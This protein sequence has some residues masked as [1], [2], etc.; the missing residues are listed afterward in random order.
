MSEQLSGSL[1]PTG[2]ITTDEVKPQ[3]PALAPKY[4]DEG[5]AKLVTGDMARAMA[6]QQ[7]K[8]W[9]LHWNESDVLYQSPRG[10]TNFD[11]SVVS[12]ANVSRFDVAKHVNSLAPMIESGLFYETPPFVIRPRPGQKQNT[13]FA[14]STLY[15]ALLDEIEFQDECVLAIEGM[16]NSGTCICKGGWVTE[17]RK[18][19]VQ[20]RKDAPLRVNMPFTS[21]QAV[22]HT[23]ESDQ[24]EVIETEITVNRPFFE[25]IPLGAV[26]VD[27]GWRHANRLDKAKYVIHQTFPTYNDLDKLRPAEGET[28]EPGIGYD[29]P[30]EEE[31]KAYFFAN[32]TNAN[33][34]GQFENDQTNNSLAYHPEGRNEITTEDPTEHPIE[35]LER[36]DNTYVRT[37][38]R[39]GDGKVVVIRNE[40]HGM[41]RHGRGSHCFMSAN[42]WN[43]PGAGYGIGV[44]RLVGSDQRISKGLVDGA[45]DILSYSLNPSYARARGANV[46]TQQIRTRLA[47][48]VDVDTEPGRG[49]RDAFGLIEQPKTPAEVFPILQMSAQS[50]QST[51]GADE[52]F[53][54]G[55]LPGK[56]GSSAARTATGAGGI[57]AANAGKIQGPVGRFVRGIFLPF[58]EMLDE[59]V[60]ER[61]PVSE[62]RQILGDQL[63][64]DFELDELDFLNSNDKFEVLAGAKLAAKKAMAQALPLMIQVIENPALVQQLNAMGYAVD[65]KLLFD[66]FM[67]VSEWKDRRELIR[68]MTPQEQKLF[69]QNNPGLQK[70]QGNLAEIAAKHQAKTAEIDQNHEASLASKMMLQ[71]GEAA[72]GYV[73]RQNQRQLMREGPFA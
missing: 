71:S 6:F 53:T 69:Q 67:E 45:L 59:M 1:D 34:P 68:P 51:T 44:G 41:S 10:Q 50:A 55:S 8:Q 47:G 11:N 33:P 52:A 66:M 4:T 73:E 60:K 46:P 23:K 28:K 62:I 5:T 27:P 3:G 72:A 22:V 58:I 40:Q 35:M 19:K 56:G 16:V 29:I 12:R 54:Q 31:L 2:K 42:F 63:G 64:D 70:V 57:I 36:W 38:L 26:F 17:P 9:A 32:E 61:M 21:K 20:V 37:V 7:E 13:A 15:G 48:I 30:S 43:I 14:K 39:Q 18:V 25:Y 49:V 65:A 24:F